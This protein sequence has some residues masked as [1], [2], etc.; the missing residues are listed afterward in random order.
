LGL[1]LGLGLVLDPRV[2]FYDSAMPSYSTKRSKLF[3]LQEK[4]RQHTQQQRK[5]VLFIIPK[6]LL[7]DFMERLLYR[8][9]TMHNFC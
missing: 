3:I 5:N 1:G 4:P 6:A 8:Y 9:C 2:N 7:R